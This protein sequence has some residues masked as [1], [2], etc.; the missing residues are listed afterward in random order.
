MNFFGSDYPLS[1]NVID[2]RNDSWWQPYLSGL[3]NNISA[4]AQ[5]PFVPMNPRPPAMNEDDLQELIHNYKTGRG[6]GNF[7]QGPYQ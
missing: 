4:L 3:L 7:L 5:N 2:R 1:Q 6:I